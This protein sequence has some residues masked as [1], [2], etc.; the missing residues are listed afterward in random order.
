MREKLALD[1]FGRKQ[2]RKPRE[3]QVFSRKRKFLGQILLAKAVKSTENC[4]VK[5]KSR[6]A[7]TV[8]LISEQSLIS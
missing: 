7:K 4:L 8:E 3:S 5:Q 2:M 6:V 1:I